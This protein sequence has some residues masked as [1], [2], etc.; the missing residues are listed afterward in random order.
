MASTPDGTCGFGSGGNLTCTGQIKS[1]ATT[2]N[3][4][5]VETYSVQ[6][7]ENWMEDF[8]SGELRNGVAVI[9][10]DADF[11]ETVTADA[12]Y[13]VFITPN[14]DSE[15]LYVINKTANSFEVRESKGGTSSLTFDYRIVG[16]RRGF[17]TQR[18]TDVTE[19]FNTERAHAMP[20]SN[21]A[22]SRT[23]LQPHPA[24]TS[25]GMPL[26]P[27]AHGVVHQLPQTHPAPIKV[28]AGGLQAMN[29]R[30]KVQ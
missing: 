23:T 17:E 6:S 20:V 1:L 12:S 19:R 25:P 5:K 3:A 9:T 24:I 8:G 4:R 10:I 13:H 26:A 2:G 18:L 7:P 21:A 16:K 11:A 15:G 30:S 28:G 14:G 22:V 27:G 29:H